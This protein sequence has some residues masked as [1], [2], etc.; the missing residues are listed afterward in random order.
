MMRRIYVT[1]IEIIEKPTGI[2][3]DRHV[4]SP[5]PIGERELNLFRERIQGWRFTNSHGDEVY[6]GMSKEAQLAIGLPF[7]AFENLQKELRDT[8]ES[9]RAHRSAVNTAN[10]WRRFKYL[11]KFKGSLL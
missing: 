6:I 9:L 10:F 7:E 3:F 8:R 5:T 2:S 1:R 4:L 11:F